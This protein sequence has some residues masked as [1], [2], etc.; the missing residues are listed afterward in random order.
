[1]FIINL[2]VA[3]V[4]TMLIMGIIGSIPK[5]PVHIRIAISIAFVIAM[6]FFI[7]ELTG[8]SSFWDV[9]NLNAL[10]NLYEMK[11]K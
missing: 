6:F 4:L 7:K 1:M 9:I 3:F 11:K 10:E 2:I 8:A 5:I